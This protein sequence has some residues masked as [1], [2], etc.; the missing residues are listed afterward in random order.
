MFSGAN[1][2]DAQALKCLAA[3]LLALLR[4]ADGVIRG[5]DE[6]FVVI[7]AN[8]PMHGA[9]FVVDRIIRGVLGA[10]PDGTP[11]TV[12]LYV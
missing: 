3:E 4:L 10:G 2:N 12:C 11:L 5:G 9:S 8:T 7:L 1:P 6:Q